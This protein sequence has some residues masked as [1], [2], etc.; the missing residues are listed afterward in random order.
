MNNLYRI[1]GI[2]CQGDDCRPVC[3]PKQTEDGNSHTLSREPGE[4]IAGCEKCFILIAALE[5]LVKHCD[6]ISVRLCTLNLVLCVSVV[7]VICGNK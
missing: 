6:T 2:V 5:G 1:P 7:V 4:V 3:K